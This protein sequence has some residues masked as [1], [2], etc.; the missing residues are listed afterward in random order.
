[1]FSWSTNPFPFLMWFCALVFQ[2]SE[3]GLPVGICTVKTPG[4]EWS[5]MP[6]CS[7]WVG[8][9]ARMKVC[10]DVLALDF[11]ERDESGLKFSVI[12]FVA[13]ERLP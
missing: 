5:N 10:K 3:R 12:L 7:V 11:T 4:E 8:E 2:V 13:L 1:M 6:W 9:W